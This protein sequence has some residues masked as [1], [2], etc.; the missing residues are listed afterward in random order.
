[1]LIYSHRQTRL[2][3]RLQLLCIV[4]LPFTYLLQET[5]G[6]QLRR[7]ETK[8][9]PLQ[10][11]ERKETREGE[12]LVL[13]L[14]SRRNIQIK[15]RGGLVASKLADA[16]QRNNQATPRYELLDMLD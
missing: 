16:R 11:L 9:K 15:S 8:R 14:M 12:D 5:S 4:R 1:M 7:G 3:A 13:S 10:E 2:L 6:R